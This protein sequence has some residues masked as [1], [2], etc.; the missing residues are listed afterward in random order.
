MESEAQLVSN[1]STIS[2][3]LFI[4]YLKNCYNIYMDNLHNLISI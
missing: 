1:Y 2:Y 4:N 3:M